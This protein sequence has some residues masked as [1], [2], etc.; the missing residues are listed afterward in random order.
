LLLVREAK[1]RTI[2][3]LHEDNTTKLNRF[4]PSKTLAETKLKMSEIKP[5]LLKEKD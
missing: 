4:K 2:R 1:K 3:Y 5:I